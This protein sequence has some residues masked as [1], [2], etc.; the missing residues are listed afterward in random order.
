[1]KTQ[2]DKL[3]FDDERLFGTKGVVHFNTTW[4]PSGPDAYIQ[5]RQRQNADGTW[6]N[7]AI[8]TFVRKPLR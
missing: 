1:M 3:I 4:V 5:N 2:G 7:S 6:T 8:G